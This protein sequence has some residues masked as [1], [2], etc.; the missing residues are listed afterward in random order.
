MNEWMNEWK[1]EIKNK[2]KNEWKSEIENGCLLNKPS[3]LCLVDRVIDLT[4]RVQ[5]V[6]W[7]GFIKSTSQKITKSSKIHKSGCRPPI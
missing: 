6:K 7:Q 1:S 4:S 5:L 3:N 2:L